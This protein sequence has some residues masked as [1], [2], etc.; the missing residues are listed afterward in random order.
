MFQISRQWAI[1]S[2]EPAREL[3]ESA[4][5]SVRLVP[6]GVI[7]I[8]L[9]MIGMG[10]SLANAQGIIPGEPVW[11]GFR[12]PDVF[13][14]N[15]GQNVDLRFVQPHGLAAGDL[16][17]DGWVDVAVANN[18][19]LADHGRSVSVFL[20]TRDWRNE[21]GLPSGL[22]SAV[23]Y[24][25]GNIEA[26]SYLALGDLDN[27]GDLDIAVSHFS[28]DGWGMT[29]FFNQGVH[30]GT[31]GSPVNYG[32]GP[33]TVVNTYAIVI[34]DFDLNGFNDVA[35]AGAAWVADAPFPTLAVYWSEGLDA[36]N[37]PIWS[38]EQYQVPERSGCIGHALAV[39]YFDD[40]PTM[41]PYDL[42]MSD[43]KCSYVHVFLN[44]P[45][46]RNFVI[47]SKDAVESQGI[48]ANRFNVGA[49]V[50]LALSWHNE[51]R[52]K[53]MAGNGLGHFVLQ[54]PP[55]LVDRDVWGIA[56]GRLSIDTANDIVTANRAQNHSQGTVSV[57]LGYGDGTF[58]T[59]RLD[60]LVDPNADGTTQKPWPWP[61]QVILADM[62]NDTY[63]DVVT[64]N[65]GSG[66]ISVLV[67]LGPAV[68]P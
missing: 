50:D 56:S 37:R 39:E 25:L 6:G 65:N 31:F 57:L 40:P 13:K 29:V 32:P 54:D 67:N 38:R 27:D 23:V 45:G 24:S 59:P 15:P 8:C 68:M 55:F 42:A 17:N 22:A 14:T 21:S 41:G 52:V 4:R 12:T 58:K 35:L 46:E 53:W 33:L 3:P 9:L 26:P 62:N 60:Y 30:S 61:Q 19:D 49:E 16:N 43:P 51:R 11:N 47:S 28:F 2:V 20:N 7:M 66:S 44:V 36:Q 1:R 48:T 10:T 63:N 34:R 18:G 64:S 5:A